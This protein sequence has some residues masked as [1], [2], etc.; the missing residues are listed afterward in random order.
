[1]ANQEM[2]T[3]LK[4]GKVADFNAHRVEHPDEEFNLRG[5][6]LSG[7]DLSEASLSEADLRGANLSGADLSG[8]DLRG[9][10]LSGA[11][12]YGADL[13]GA[14]LTDALGLETAQLIGI[15]W[16]NVRGVRREIV[17]ASHLLTQATI[18]FTD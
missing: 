5:A 7:A 8:A 17:Q 3:S 9:A 18:K 6:N 16:F 10:D 1:M 14:K 4:A 11:N 13:S 12:L 2:I 15:N